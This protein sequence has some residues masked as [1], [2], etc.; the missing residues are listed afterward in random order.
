MCLMIGFAGGRRE[1]GYGSDD[2]LCKLAGG[3]EGGQRYLT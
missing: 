1:R 3:S 2:A